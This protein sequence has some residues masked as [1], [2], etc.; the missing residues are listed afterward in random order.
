MTIIVYTPLKNNSKN[1]FD[2]IRILKNKFCFLN[3]RKTPSSEK[4]IENNCGEKKTKNRTITA[5]SLVKLIILNNS[6]SAIKN[7]TF[8]NPNKIATIPWRNSNKNKLRINAA[9]IP[10]KYFITLINEYGLKILFT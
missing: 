5:F 3:K 7:E 4:N 8:S 10:T 1:K 6:K 2:I 9:K